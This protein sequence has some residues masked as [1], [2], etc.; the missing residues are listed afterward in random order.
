MEHERE[1]YVPHIEID[2]N[3][4]EEG[5]DLQGGSGTQSKFVL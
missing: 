1:S 5:G 3:A 4:R 2:R